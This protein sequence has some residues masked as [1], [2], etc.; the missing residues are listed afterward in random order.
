[1]LFSSVCSLTEN[2]LHKN[3]IPKPNEKEVYDWGYNHVSP[4]QNHG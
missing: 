1:M 4:Y 3:R 2:T